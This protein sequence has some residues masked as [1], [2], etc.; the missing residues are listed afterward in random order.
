MR[1]IG[2]RSERDSDLIVNRVTYH[3]MQ[4]KSETE[5][6]PDLIGMGVEEDEIPL[7][8]KVARD[9][10]AAALVAY[11]KDQQRSALGWMAFGI[12]M[13]GLAFYLSSGDVPLLRQGRL[14]LA[15]LAGGGALL[16]GIWRY[17]DPNWK[18]DKL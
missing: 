15:W 11:Q 18:G 12:A 2:D 5:I 4:G 7:L 1:K 10:D 14:A 8:I 17:L 16:Y 9:R 3:L 13:L 6:T